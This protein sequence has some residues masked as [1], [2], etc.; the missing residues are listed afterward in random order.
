MQT[1]TNLQDA[2]VASAIPFHVQNLLAPITKNQFLEQYW[3]NRLLHVPRSQA[4]YYAALFS[5]EALEQVLQCAQIKPPDIRVVKNQIEVLPTRYQRADGSIHMNQLYKAYDE[6][7]SIIINGLQRFWPAVATFC[8][9]LQRVLSHSIV[10]NCYLSPANS[11]A[12]QPHYDTHDVFVV[13]VAGSK[14]WKFHGSPQPVPLHNSFQPVIPEKNLGQPTDE[15]LVQSGDLVYIPRGVIHHA[16]TTDSFSFHMTLGVHPMQWMDL[17]QQALT[18]LSLQD[19]RFRKALPVGFLDAENGDVLIEGFAALVA[20]FH[21]KAD[22]QEAFAMLKHQFL[23]TTIPAPDGHFE[24]LNELS[25]IT[26]ETQVEKRQELHCQLMDRGLSVSL[27]FPGNTI[28]GPASY[29]RA[30]KFVAEITRPFD[31]SELPGLELAN[32]IKLAQRLIRGGLLKRS[33]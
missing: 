17:L 33:S 4:G 23:Q 20:V 22:V 32:Q 15:I 6:G 10:A 21:E 12:L 8:N 2:T 11:K 28:G 9:Q 26:A 29:R 31:V 24:H 13:Q 16:E 3:E 7:H 30:M 14:T 18:A 5:V 25:S 19:E 1:I 27:K